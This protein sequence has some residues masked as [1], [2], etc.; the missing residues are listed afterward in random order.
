MSREKSVSQRPHPY[1]Y[2]VH[3]MYH[4][5]QIQQYQQYSWPNLYQHS[6]PQ[7]ALHHQRPHP[8]RQHIPQVERVGHGQ[9][10][11]Q[12]HQHPLPVYNPKSVQHYEVQASMEEHKYAESLCKLCSDDSHHVHHHHVSSQAIREFASK[13]QGGYKFNCILCKQDESV[14]RPSTR[15][16][17]LTDSTLYNVWTYRDLEMPIHVEIESIVGGRIR[18]LTRALI[19]LFLKH[20]SERLEIIVIAGINN[21]GDSQPVDDIMEEVS[22]LKQVVLAHSTLHGHKEPSCVSLSTVLYA[23]K[24]CSLDVP[25]HLKEWI[26]PPGF[27][28]KREKIESL[29][30]AI[31][32]VNK[33]DKVNYLN[34]HYEGV[35]IDK[36]SGHKSHRHQQQ[37]WREAE[38]RRRLHLNPAHKVKLMRRATKLFMGGLRNVGSWDSSA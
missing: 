4:A 17:I 19:M 34:I 16:V 9:A 36:A 21:V 25:I 10:L 2:E 38:V 13:F 18:D 35:R 1:Q 37:I 23:P 15:K 6:N 33:C 8:Y 3:N 27:V 32:A 29:N 24:F 28:N 31:A 14:V 5:R 26:P 30:A 12:S 22:E 11:Q 20:Y 7:Q